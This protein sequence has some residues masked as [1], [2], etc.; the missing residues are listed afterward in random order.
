M[1]IVFFLSSPIWPTRR[2]RGHIAGHLRWLPP[3]AVN[4]QLIDLI[5]SVPT[6]KV[7]RSDSRLDQLSM[8]LP[9]PDRRRRGEDENDLNK[10]Y[11]TSIQTSVKP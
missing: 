10:P 2:R 9:H 4:L 3:E 1:V 6:G 5:P 8:P 7:E 11:K